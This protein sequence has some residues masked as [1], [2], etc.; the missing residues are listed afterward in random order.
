MLYVLSYTNVEEWGPKGKRDCLHILSAVEGGSVP[1][2]EPSGCR[3]L[4][5]KSYFF[6][7]ISLCFLISP[8][9]SPI[10]FLFLLI[11]IK[12]HHLLLDLS[13]T[14]C[15]PLLCSLS[16]SFYY[17]IFLK[18]LFFL[19]SCFPSL[20]VHFVVVKACG[21]DAIAG[22]G[23]QSVLSLLILRQRMFPINIYISNWCT[24]CE[25]TSMTLFIFLQ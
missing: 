19:L 6:F 23:V 16:F 25:V 1:C 11:P 9:S 2:S 3:R 14:R 10:F 12:T 22:Q 8:L 7:F 17:F 21:T 18:S 13:S 24:L 20:R 15:F 4:P 5:P